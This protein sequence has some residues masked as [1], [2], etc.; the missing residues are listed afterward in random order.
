MSELFTIKE[1][2][3][4]QS[5]MTALLGLET[6]T[7]LIRFKI[8]Y[9]NLIIDL[10]T[11]YHNE[12]TFKEYNE[13][14]WIV[15]KNIRWLQ[16]ELDE[17]EPGVQRLILRLQDNKEDEEYLMNSHLRVSEYIKYWNECYEEYVKKRQSLET[18]EIHVLDTFKCIEDYKNTN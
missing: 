5:K 15:K 17:H 13:Y 16:E 18:G 14:C 3:F 12:Y 8:D 11:D 2:I 4:E 10:L 6:N 7:K 9:L 1:N